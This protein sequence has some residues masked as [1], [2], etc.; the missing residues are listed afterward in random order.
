MAVGFL[1]KFVRPFGLTLAACALTAPA[2][3]A[4]AQPGF[5][6]EQPQA[7]DFAENQRQSHP[8][9]RNVARAEWD[10]G[11]RRQQKSSNAVDIQVVPLPTPPLEIEIFHFAVPS[12]AER[13]PIAGTMCRGV[14]GDVPIRL[15][16][17][18]ANTPTSPASVM[19]IDHI[20]A[21][22]PLIISILAAN[23][24]LDPQAIYSVNLSVSTRT[25]DFEQ[26]NITETGVD[27]GRFVGILNTAAVPPEPVKRNCVLSVNRG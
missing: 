2:A 7:P 1:T 19:P 17:A 3:T 8:L 18:F 11:S 13:L 24:N 10:I 23:R 20:R 27:S 22:E 14:Q 25:G 5:A 4:L 9:I 6:D 26:I 15:G 16:G 21:G 12:G